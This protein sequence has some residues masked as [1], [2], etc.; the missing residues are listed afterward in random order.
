[1]G[2]KKKDVINKPAKPGQAL[3]AFNNRILLKLGPLAR[4]LMSKI[5]AIL[6]PNIL[7]CER[8]NQH[9]LNAWVI[10]NFDFKKKKYRKRLHPFRP[11]SKS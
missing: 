1:M 6:P 3:T 7:F 8:V 9:E 11:K 5:K 2:K 4:Y 10:K